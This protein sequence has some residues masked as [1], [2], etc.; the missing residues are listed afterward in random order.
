[1]KATR[2][3]NMQ[4]IEIHLKGVGDPCWADWFQDLEI[5]T[6]PNNETSIKGEIADNSAIY[7]I[8]SSVSSLGLS[9]ISITVSDRAPVQSDS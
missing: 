8:L 4:F 6:L 7:G 3:S 1:M 2:S 5:Q 9:L